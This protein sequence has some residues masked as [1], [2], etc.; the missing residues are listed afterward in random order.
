MATRWKKP[1]RQ[2]EK[3]ELKYNLRSFLNQNQDC[4]KHFTYI[5]KFKIEVTSGN[6]GKLDNLKISEAPK[7]RQDFQ[8]F[9][10]FQQVLI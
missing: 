1:G 8:R 2:F 3:H 6:F 4:Q 5:W 9:H 10:D 7:K